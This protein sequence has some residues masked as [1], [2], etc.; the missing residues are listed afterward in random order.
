MV[1]GAGDR[2]HA[3]TRTPC[4]TVTINSDAFPLAVELT[5]LPEAGFRRA[6]E[7]L[8]PI[9]RRYSPVITHSNEDRHD[10]LLSMAEV[11]N[12][13]FATEPEVAAAFHEINTAV[14]DWLAL[15]ASVPLL[16]LR[17]K[18]QSTL[19]TVLIRRSIR[20]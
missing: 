17:R 4:Y 10:L 12:G 15:S 18:S 8:S 6:A 19:A 13:D 7:I 3:Q 14:W 16:Q 20:Q 9:F 2:L 11:A 5:F 1:T